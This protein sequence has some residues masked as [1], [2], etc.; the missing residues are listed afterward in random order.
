MKRCILV[1]FLADFGVICEQG[2]PAPWEEDHG[3]Y[4]I[5]VR[6]IHKPFKLICYVSSKMAHILIVPL[7][8]L[9]WYFQSR[10]VRNY[11]ARFIW[12]GR[13]VNSMVVRDEVMLNHWPKA[14][15]F[16]SKVK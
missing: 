4:A 1:S 5:I 9:L 8:N 2:V 7:D 14:R 3:I 15:Y 10:L 16:T 12:G 11:P 6:T 13:G